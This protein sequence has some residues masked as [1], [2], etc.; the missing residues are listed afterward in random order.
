MADRGTDQRK[1]RCCG[2]TYAYPEK[3]SVSTRTY[4]ENCEAI[5]TETRRAIERVRRRVERVVRKM[6]D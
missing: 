5:P 1:C 4:C 2:E 3:K 6:G